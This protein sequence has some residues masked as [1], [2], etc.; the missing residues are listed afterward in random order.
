MY[1]RQGPQ[2]ISHLPAFGSASAPPQI[3]MPP[4]HQSNLQFNPQNPNSFQQSQPFEQI[5]QQESRVS[6]KEESIVCLF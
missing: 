5:S 3:A 4:S 2:D 1:Q 6:Q